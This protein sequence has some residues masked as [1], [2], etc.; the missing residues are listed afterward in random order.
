MA[1]RATDGAELACVPAALTP[2]ERAVHFA[3]IRQLFGELV[4]ERADLEDG[5]AYRFQPHAFET[6][7]RFVANERKCCP[8]LNFE[9]ALAAGSG[10]LWLRMTGPAGTRAFLNGE[11][12]VSGST[13]S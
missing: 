3:L 1:S 13:S 11:L 4:D 8:F 2:D 5:Y 9:L 7:V 10:T 6:V 12:A